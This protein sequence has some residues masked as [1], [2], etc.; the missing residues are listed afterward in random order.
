MNDDNESALHPTI[1]QS[2]WSCSHWMFIW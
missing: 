1:N 2:G